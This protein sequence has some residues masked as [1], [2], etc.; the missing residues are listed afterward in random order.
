MKTRSNRT[1][2]GYI[3][4]YDLNDLD[5]GI[6]GNN[7]NYTICLKESP[8]TENFYQGYG[9]SGGVNYT[10]PSQWV[11]LPGVTGG[12]IVVGAYAVY[13][14]D[15]N[16]A[17]FTIN[18]SSGNYLVN[19][20]DGTTG[21]FASGVAAYKQYTTTTYSGLTSDVFR[22]YKTLLITITPVT[23]G[24]NITSVD[25]V[26]KHNQSGLASYYSNGWL[27]LRISA[28]SCTQALFSNYNFSNQNRS[29]KLEQVEWIGESPIS[30]VSF[31]GCTSLKKIVSFP[32][33]R[34]VTTGWSSVFHSCHLLQEIPINMDFSR[35]SGSFNYVFY[36]CYNLR[37]V[38]PL[39]TKNCTSM[40]G[41][42]INCVCLSRIPYLDTSNATSLDSLFYNCQAVEYVPYLDTRKCTNGN[43]IYWNCKKL[44]QIQPELAGASFTSLLGT[45][46]STAILNAPTINT[47]NVTTM[48]SMFSSCL[49]LKT[50]PQ[51]N[52]SSCTNIGSMFSSCTSLEFVPDFN[53]PSTLA[54]VDSLFNEC[55]NLQYCPGITMGTATSVANMFYRCWNMHSIPSTINFSNVA[56]TT[57]AF[58]ENFSLSSCGITGIS[59][60]VDFTNA[61]MG[62][63]ALNNLYTSLQT[64]VRTITV[65]G[66][67]G[68]A[69]DNPSIATAKGWTVTG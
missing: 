36:N 54:T 44:K 8:I 12:N 47:A 26:T 3:G 35:A 68:T 25:L 23:A 29:S 16:F 27:D 69:S 43:Y 18:T 41:I 6:I 33:C 9:I 28:P 45:F 67:W 40:V 59:R 11:P 15:S 17:S 56:T 32:S 52:F 60:N 61:C 63:T 21:S 34:N 2:N 1:N 5:N 31:L 65:T 57:T 4:A 66:N 37:K 46:S 39:Y 38:P 50:I 42:F 24:A 62:P 19:W 22:N 14:T 10:R 30:S 20:G 53:T 7:K 58:F 49:T 55:R 13:N 64:A 48:N 51:Y